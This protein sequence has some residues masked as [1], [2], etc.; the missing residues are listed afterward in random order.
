MTQRGRASIVVVVA[1]ALVASVWLA[2]RSR[3]VDLPPSTLSSTAVGAPPP[4]DGPP[5]PPP[6]EVIERLP[7]S[8]GALDLRVFAAAGSDVGRAS[9]TSVYGRL[10]ET[11][12]V[13]G[14]GGG[15]ANPLRVEYTAGA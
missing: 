7:V 11:L 6:R 2:L 5:L 14:P 1:A 8:Q 12:P 3:P 13:A 9:E 10:Y 4:E 15:W